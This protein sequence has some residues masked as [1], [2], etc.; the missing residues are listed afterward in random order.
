MSDFLTLILAI[1]TAASG[2][3]LLKKAALQIGKLSFT[4]ENFISELFKIFTN[5]W[6]FIGLSFYV[7][8]FLFWIKT[9]SGQDLSKVYPILVS[10]T[11]TIILIGSSIFFKEQLS[12]LRILGILIILAGIYIV[13]K[14]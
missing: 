11:I 9:I 5:P 10:A 12:F 1:G 8:G 2:N 6:I 13:F 4:P 14:T 7:A 3:L